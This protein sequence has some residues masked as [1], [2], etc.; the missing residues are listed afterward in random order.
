[1]NRRARVSFFVVAFAVALAVGTLAPSLYAPTATISIFVGARV[2]TNCT[3]NSSLPVDFGDYAGA[4]VDAE[5]HVLITCTNGTPHSIGL[6]Q[7]LH[8]ADGSTAE[9]PLRRM[10]LQGSPGNFLSYQLYR[11]APGIDVWGDIGTDNDKDGLVG[12]AVSV[13]HTVFGRLPGGQP[14]VASLNS[15][16]DSVLVTVQF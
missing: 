4:Q 14:A 6:G 2:I 10:E 15:Y 16:D 12:T 9:S 11:T 1:M 13:D 3:F 8:P 5:G 7:G